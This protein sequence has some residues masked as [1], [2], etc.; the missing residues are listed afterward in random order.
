[1]TQESDVLSPE[2][3]GFI[4]GHIDSVAMLEI[5]LF[6][7]KRQERE[8][9]I[10]QVSVELRSSSPAIGT[11]AQ[12]LFKKGLLKRGTSEFSYQYEPSSKELDG[13]VEVLSQIYPKYQT[14]IID[15]IYSPQ[16]RA[17]QEFADA[18]RLKREDE[19]G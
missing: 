17:I 7:R 4:S 16:K 5:L 6:F 3:R 13:L 15:Q 19:D 10:E 9:T 1:M 11:R 14:R 12:Q 18:F 2:I 8:W